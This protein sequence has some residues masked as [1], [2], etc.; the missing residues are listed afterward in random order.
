MQ[1]VTHRGNGNQKVEKALQWRLTVI[2]RQD[3]SCEMVLVK[4][5][6]KSCRSMS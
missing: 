1:F 6:S 4:E 3:F 5:R 2:G